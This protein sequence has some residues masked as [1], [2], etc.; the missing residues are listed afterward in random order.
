[1]LNEKTLEQILGIVKTVAKEKLER[2][3]SENNSDIELQLSIAFSVLC[4]KEYRH[5]LIE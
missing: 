1:M 5:L 2:K 4:D 3:N